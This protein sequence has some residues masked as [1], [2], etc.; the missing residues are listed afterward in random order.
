M[1]Q[2]WLRALVPFVPGGDSATGDRGAHAECARNLTVRP[3]GRPH[4]DKNQ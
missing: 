2:F 3:S 4:L 1:I